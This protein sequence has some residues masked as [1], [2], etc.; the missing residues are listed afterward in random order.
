[1]F[2]WQLLELSSLLKDFLLFYVAFAGE[3]GKEKLPS[4]TETAN[5]LTAV[6]TLPYSI[7]NFKKIV[8]R[9]T[10]T[11]DFSYQKGVNNL[12]MFPHKN[13]FSLYSDRMPANEHH[14]LPMFLEQEKDCRPMCAS[15]IRV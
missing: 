13:L 15:F 12:K 6:L 11:L 8:F 10:Y 4:G 5:N 14:F 3:E 9:Y 1:M 2:T 7:L